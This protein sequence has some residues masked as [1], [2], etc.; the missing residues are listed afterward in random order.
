MIFNLHSPWHDAEE[1]SMTMDLPIL[2]LGH[3][4]SIYKEFLKL[5]LGFAL[6][7]RIFSSS[8]FEPW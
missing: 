2:D 8:V 7:I 6:E 5:L 4:T 3:G 1:G